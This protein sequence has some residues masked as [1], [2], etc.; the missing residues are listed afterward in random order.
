MRSPLSA[1]ARAL[2]A[3]L[4]WLLDVPVY[5]SVPDGENYP[6]VVV[7][8]NEQDGQAT[9][10]GKVYAADLSIDVYS[11]QL[12]DAEI[13]G[14]IGTIQDDL[15]TTALD[16]SADGFNAT[17][18]I[19]DNTSKAVEVNRAGKRVQHAVISFRMFTTDQQ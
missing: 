9:A 7:G 6:Y 16:L 14:H 10:D 11:D 12:G 15:L 4:D 8:D 1:I 3:R 18:L 13:N 5:S 2:Y 19:H 17:N